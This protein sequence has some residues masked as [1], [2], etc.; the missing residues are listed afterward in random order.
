TIVGKKDTCPFCSE[1]VSLKAL[2]ANPWESQSLMFGNLL[3]AVRY[4]IVWNPVIVGVTQL[5]LYESG[6]MKS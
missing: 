1:K 5:F 4:L 2:L 3:D 6:V